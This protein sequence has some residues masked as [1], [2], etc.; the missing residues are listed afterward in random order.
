MKALVNSAPGRLEL[1]E[2]PLPEPGPGQVRIRTAFCGICATDLEMIA[3]WTKAGEQAGEGQPSGKA[4]TGFPSVPGHEW[5]GIVDALGSGVDERLLG[6]PCVAENILEDGGEVGFEHP[7]G[8]GEYLINL[9]RNVIVL[10]DSFPLHQAVLIEPLAVCMRA[11]RR[12][13]ITDRRSALVIGDGPVGLLMLLLL[14]RAGVEEVVVA[15]GRAGRLALAREFGVSTVVD[16]RRCDSLEQGLREAHPAPFANV[17]EASGS[18]QGARAAVELAARE[19]HVLIV[20]DYQH[21]RAAFRWND[22]LHREIELIGSNASAGGWA[23]AVAA[24]VS[25]ELPLERMISAVYPVD[26]H[27]R[28]FERVRAQEEDVVKVALSWPVA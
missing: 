15:G 8:Y 22:L 6:R 5:S 11:I 17:V 2:R 12:L 14:R 18:A 9:A 3:G 10:P 28:A 7:G 27:R 23:E 24:A 21:A 1:L 26:E 25:G 19:G 4:R 13:R 20:G 16:H